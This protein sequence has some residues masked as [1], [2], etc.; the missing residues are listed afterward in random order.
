MAD[1]KRQLYVLGDIEGASGIFPDNRDAMNHGSEAWRAQGR[2]IMTSDVLAVCEAANEFGID[3]IILNDAHDNG[4]RTPNVIPEELPDNVRLVRRPYLLGKPR[5][6]VQG[7]PYGIVIVGQH[8]MAGGGGFAPHTIS[9]QFAEVTINGILV[10]EIGIELALFM[11]APLLAVIGE[12]RAIDE[13]HE[14]CPNCVGVPVKSLEQD[15]LLTPEEAFPRIKAGTFE[16][17]EQ[18]DA[19]RGLDLQPPFRFMLRLDRRMQFEP[20]KRF[21]L[22]SLM[23][24]LLFRRCRGAMT[25]REVSWEAKTI[26]GGLYM[27]HAMRAYM[28]RIP[29]N[30]A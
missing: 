25:D 8:A 11:G 23:R 3:E 9:W 10:G 19:M 12:Q 1:S 24:H 6:M 29:T 16:S 4:K 20:D 17:L 15:W 22:S 27:L 26:I 2:S 18:R 30:A 5:H 28:T 7:D 14:L 13:A 21:F